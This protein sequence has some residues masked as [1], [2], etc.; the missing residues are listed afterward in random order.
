MGKLQKIATL[1]VII[2]FILL[3]VSSKVQEILLTRKTE[4]AKEPVKISMGT[5]EEEFYENHSL[6]IQFHL[7]EKWERN[8]NEELATMMNLD[9]NVDFESAEFQASLSNMKS[10]YYVLANNPE[11]GSSLS[12]FSEK[13]SD[14]TTVE[15]YLV[16]IK[17]QLESLK[18]F[19]YQIE[20]TDKE[21]V[22]KET[23]AT[24]VAKVS[25]YGM[26]Q[27]YYVRKLGDYFISI[28]IST[29]DE[30]ESIESIIEY[31]G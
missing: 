16:G 23:Y 2:A 22:G 25:D 7:P 18:E 4:H 28:I 30:S 13:V 19:T 6:G 31:F 9:K 15:K 5:W 17:A 14:G 12:I 21:K 29:L 3:L 10:I 11:T 26:T 1:C 27:K 8:A 24:L 20:I